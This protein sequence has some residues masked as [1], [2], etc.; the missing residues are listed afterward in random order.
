MA[1][2]LTNAFVNP[3]EVIRQLDVAPG[4]MAAD[5]G[6]GSGFFSMVFAKMAG[7]HGMVYAL[8]ILPSSL[9]AVA[10]RAKTLGL[11]NV[12]T[13]RVNLEHEGG[14]KLPDNSLDWVILKD[15]LF[16]NTSKETIVREA[17]RVLKQGGCLLLMEWG[18]GDF[19]FGPEKSLRLPRE[20][21][22]ELLSE[23]GFVPVKDVDAGDFHYAM[24]CQK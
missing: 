13:K 7:E 15:I 5:F 9:E 12:V 18:D 22:I 8:D 3:E 20:K 4:T 14:S 23:Q 6:C 17:Y 16:Q 21:A 10:S 24:V 2:A 19:S 1:S 11:S